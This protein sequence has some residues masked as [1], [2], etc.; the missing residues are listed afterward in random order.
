LKPQNIL[1][2]SSCELVICDFGLARCTSSPDT[3][4]NDVGEPT[5]DSAAGVAALTVYVVTR[6]YRAP[7]LLLGSPVYSDPV[8][9]W[10]VGC[11]LAEILGRR[12]LFRGSNY[13]HQ[14]QVIVEVLGTPTEHDM[15]LVQRKSAKEAIDRMGRRE[16]VPFSKLFPRANPQAVDLLEK[17]LVFDPD[18]RM[19]AVV[20]PVACCRVLR[21]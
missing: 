5:E 4:L 16:K 17:L 8:D 12:P 10:S 2:N 18:K 1:V 6:W 19:T 15:R 14:L 13:V 9:M 3:A 21:E 7:E 20:R 11:I